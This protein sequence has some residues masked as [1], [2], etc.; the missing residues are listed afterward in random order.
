MDKREK[1][2]LRD[3]YTGQLEM[4]AEKARGLK[5]SSRPVA[6]DDALGRLTR[7][8][9]IQAGEIQA[10]AL[11]QAQAQQAGIEHALRQMD[12]P[13]FGLCV[14]CGNPIPQARLLAVPGSRH[15]VNCA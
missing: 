4:L 8:D 10:S 13:D 14:E 2:L 6:P 7:L 11:R 3:H 15:C 1:E 5:E 12:D 9:A